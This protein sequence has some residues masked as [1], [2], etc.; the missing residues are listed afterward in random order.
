MNTV[1]IVNVSIDFDA[2]VDVDTRITNVYGVC[3]NVH[4]SMHGIAPHDDQ[5]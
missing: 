2:H 4:G 3:R 5:D 1:I